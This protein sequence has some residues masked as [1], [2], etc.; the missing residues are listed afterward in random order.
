M[1]PILKSAIPNWIVVL[2]NLG[3]YA[4]KA[5]DIDDNTPCFSV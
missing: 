3:L 2:G 5:S 1:L 4:M